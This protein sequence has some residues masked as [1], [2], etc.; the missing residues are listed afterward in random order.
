M[1]TTAIFLLVAALAVTSLGCGAKFTRQRYD[2]VYIGAP[3]DKLL[4][5]LGKPDSRDGDTWAYTNDSPWYQAKFIISENTVA[6]K[7][8][9]Y[10]RQGR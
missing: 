6:G 8:F 5:T 3:A 4:R 2:T 10:D 9:S 7:N 1:R